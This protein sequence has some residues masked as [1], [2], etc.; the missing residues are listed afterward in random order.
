VLLCDGQLHQENY[1]IGTVSRTNGLVN[2]CPK[3]KY[4][5]DGT[6]VAVTLYDYNFVFKLD[7][8]P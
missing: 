8:G 5:S 1:S 2:R 6:F 3:K 4:E 7:T